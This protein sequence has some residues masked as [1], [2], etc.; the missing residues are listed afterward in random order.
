M[1]YPPIENLVFNITDKLKSQDIEIKGMICEAA[2][3]AA[4]SLKA[5]LCDWFT[6]LI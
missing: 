2:Y 3:D 6:G 1:V 5:G 4:G